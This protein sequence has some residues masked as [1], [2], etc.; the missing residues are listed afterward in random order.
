MYTCPVEHQHT[1]MT[2]IIDLADLVYASGP[3]CD[4][5]CQLQSYNGHY[6]CPAQYMGD[7][8]RELLCGLWSELEQLNNNNNTDT[9]TT[10]FPWRLWTASM[11]E[12]RPALGHC[13]ACGVSYRPT[14]GHSALSVLRYTKLTRNG[15]S[16]AVFGLNLR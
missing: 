11:R 12:I 9:T 2:R 5:F 4:L 1:D 6:C 14:E 15:S 8:E 10:D 16:S 13:A 7:T 3:L